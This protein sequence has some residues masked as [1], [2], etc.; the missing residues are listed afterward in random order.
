MVNSYGGEPFHNI[1]INDL[2]DKALMLQEYRRD[3]PMYLLRKSDD[4]SGIYEKA[5]FHDIA[6]YIPL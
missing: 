4:H 2:E 1:V 6:V 5:Y 3:T